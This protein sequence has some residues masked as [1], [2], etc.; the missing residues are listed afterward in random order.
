MKF[1]FVVVF[2]FPNFVSACTGI[3]LHEALLITLLC[4]T[5]GLI[6]FSFILLILRFIPS[7]RDVSLVRILRRYRKLLVAIIVVSFVAAIAILF[8]LD[9]PTSYV[10]PTGKT[11]Y[12]AC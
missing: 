12:A 11:W 6:V 4:T 3:Y 9:Q 10:D 1:I 2:L 5:L 7:N 8:Y